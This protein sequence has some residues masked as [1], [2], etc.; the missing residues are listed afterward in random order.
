MWRHLCRSISRCE[1]RHCASLLHTLLQRLH[2]LTILSQVGL[3]TSTCFLACCYLSARDW[4]N[5]NSFVSKT[6]STATPGRYS[7]VCGS[8]RNDVKACQTTGTKAYLSG[9]KAYLSGT[10]AYLS[11][12]KAYLCQAL[13]T[14]FTILHLLCEIAPLAAGASSILGTSLPPTL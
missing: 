6:V 14:C 2:A 1:K 5:R 12:T 9:T 11:G 10:K 7:I 8:C 13:L 4:Y 3:Q